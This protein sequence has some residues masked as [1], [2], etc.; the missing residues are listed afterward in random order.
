MNLPRACCSKRGCCSCKGQGSH[1]D[2]RNGRDHCCVVPVHR[3]LSCLSC[4]RWHH[5]RQL[6]DTTDNLRP[7]IIGR[8]TS[9][10]SLTTAVTALVRPAGRQTGEL[11]LTAA[12]R[13]LAQLGPRSDPDELTCC[14]GV[15]AWDQALA[16]IAG[17][18]DRDRKVLD[19]NITHASVWMA[20]QTEWLAIDEG[21]N[22]IRAPCSK[23][24]GSF[25]ACQ[26]SH[27]AAQPSA[28]LAASWCQSAWLGPDMLQAHQTTC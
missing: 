17:S 4:C 22:A 9:C 5:V 18:R 7:S 12:R 14:Q 8:C 21:E 24:S 27:M 6:S 1:H 28:K 10:S 20:Q 25:R 2:H 13:Q 11:V 16:G 15:G 23:V 19:V 26:R 3:W